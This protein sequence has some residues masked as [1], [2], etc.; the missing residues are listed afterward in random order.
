M[1]VRIHKYEYPLGLKISKALEKPSILT[2]NISHN[3]TA[4]TV[5]QS[6]TVPS[7]PSVHESDNNNVSEKS[8]SKHKDPIFKKSKSRWIILLIFF[9]YSCTNGIAFITFAPARIQ[10]ERYYNRSKWELLQLTMISLYF[11]LILLFPIAW[12]TNKWFRYSMIT[13]MLLQTIGGWLRYAAS[14]SF[15]VVLVGHIFVGLANTFM[16]STPAYIGHVFFT[17]KQS[18]KAV[19]IG[20]FALYTGNALGTLLPTLFI[21]KSQ[22]ESEVADGIQMT[23]LVEAILLSVPL[24]PAIIF[25]KDRPGSYKKRRKLLEDTTN[26]HKEVDL[27]DSERNIGRDSRD[28][29]EMVKNGDKNN[30]KNK[31]GGYEDSVTQNFFPYVVQIVKQWRIFLSSMAFGMGAGIGLS[32]LAVI[33]SIFPSSFTLLQVGITGVIFVGTGILFG[34]LGQLSLGKSC[35]KGHYDMIIKLFFL[36][37]TLVL[38]FIAIFMDETAGVALVY[39]FSAIGGFGLIAFVPFAIQSLIESSQPTPEVIPTAWLQWFNELFAVIATYST[40]VAS[41]D[42]RLWVLLIMLAPATIWIMFFH[43]TEFKRSTHHKALKRHLRQLLGK[44]QNK[45][46]NR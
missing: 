4:S 31:E 11:G 17:G 10:M 24:I 15:A 5:S 18:L 16:L 3:H 30:Q 37:N 14:T 22:S 19:L 35:L 7:L 2:R 45:V 36:E 25:M 40:T 12:L 26:D 46:S 28:N 39:V 33:T 44:V 9:V 43:R 41:A 20:S 6:S 38:L 29:E 1:S 8:G 34:I 21:S 13:A 32:I 27:G 42:F 23:L